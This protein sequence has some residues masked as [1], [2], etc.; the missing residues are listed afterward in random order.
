MRYA[1]L[2]NIPGNPVKMPGAGE[3][4]KGLDPVLPGCTQ[5]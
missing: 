5:I 4:L 3:E 2:V 1:G